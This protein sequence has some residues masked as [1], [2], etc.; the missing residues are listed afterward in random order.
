ARE[1]AS[2]CGFLPLALALAGARV[3]AGASWND[4][5]SALER[6]R[7][8][9]LDHP[10]GS[11]FS[12]LR[13]STDA[14][15]EFERDRYFELAVFPED[16]VIPVAAIWTLWRHT[17]NMREDASSRDLLLRLHRRALLAR[18][19]DGGHISFH[20]L[21]HDFLRLNISSLVA[22][23]EALIDAYRAAAP[24]GWAGGPDDGYCF[25]NLPGHLPE[26][27]HPD[28]PKPLICDY[29]RLRAELA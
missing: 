13:L 10:Y 15:T 16:A 3:Q 23:N 25:Q 20:D 7:L 17:G 27:D 4:V 29:A 2:G 1:V 6:G 5:L 11:V 24:S 28:E 21:Q 19:E 9:F 26:A 22:A 14:L 18:S 8:E 12:S